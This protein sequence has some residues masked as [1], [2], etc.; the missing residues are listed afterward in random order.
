VDR[1]LACESDF[2]ERGIEI[3]TQLTEGLPQVRGDISA[4][5]RMLQNLMDNAADAMPE[6]GVLTLSTAEDDE[7]I[8]LCV[9]DTGMGMSKETAERI[10]DAFYTTKHYGSGIGLAVVWETVQAHGFDI[11]VQSTPGRGTRFEISIPKTD[12]VRYDPD[13]ASSGG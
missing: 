11:D 5:R 1:A 6:G 3:R 13:E 8:L 12:I 2:A 9:E 4:L 7:R 10:F